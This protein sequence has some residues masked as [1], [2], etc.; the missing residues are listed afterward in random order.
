MIQEIARY[1]DDE[2][3]LRAPDFIKSCMRVS[4]IRDLDPQATDLEGYLFPDTYMVPQD[5][6]ADELVE[7]MVKH[8]RRI[9]TNEVEWRARDIPLT[10]REV[11]VLASLIE[12]ETASRDERFLVSSVFHNR[13]RRQ[14]LLDCDPTIV[15]ILKK[16]NRYT[17]N[18][19]WNDLKI[20]SP[21][22]T[23][24]NRGLPPGPICNPGWDSIE[25]ALYPENTNYLYFVAK[26]HQSHQFSETLNEHNRAV[27]KYIT[28][29]RDFTRK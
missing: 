12:K 26:D 17:G 2:H 1:L 22:N 23:R 20:D 25:A 11:V 10:L 9:I 8:F 16:E 7:M 13:I 14:M 21:Y 18:L 15:Y 29:G 27:R 3:V 28:G 19:G 5:F 4:L 24:L 6:N